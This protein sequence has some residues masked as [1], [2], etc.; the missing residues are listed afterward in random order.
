VQIPNSPAAVKLHPNV[1]NTLLPLN[2]KS[3][4]HWDGS[5]SEDLPFN[6]DRFYSWDREAMREYK[7]IL[8]NESNR[9]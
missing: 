8:Y 4:R 1:L 2:M 9:E 7:H 3:G 5:Q 6:N